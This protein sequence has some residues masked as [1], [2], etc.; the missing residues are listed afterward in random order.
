M[1]APAPKPA[2]QAAG[3]ASSV[4]RHVAKHSVRGRL[5]RTTLLI[6]AVV[7]VISMVAIVA[8]DLYVYRSSWASDIATE[9]GVVAMS[10]TP[11]LAFDDR[12]A[13]T[14]NLAMLEARGSVLAVAVYAR[15]GSLFA[16]HLRSDQEVPAVA[17][18]LAGGA[19]ESIVVRGEVVEI[20]QRIVSG[21]EV[22][23]T[24]YLR[25]R[26]DVLGRIGTYLGI[27]ALIMGVGLLLARMLSARLQRSITVPLETLADVAKQV[28]Q[29]GDYGLRMPDIADDDFGI[30]VRA[31]NQMFAEVQQRTQALERSNASLLEQVAVRKDA[32]SALARANARLESTMAAAEIGSWVWN[33]KTGEFSGDRNM[34]ALYGIG[35]SGDGRAD[36]AWH[37]RAIHPQD[38]AKIEQAERAALQSGTLASPEYRIVRPDGAVRWAVSRGRVSFDADGSPRVLAGLL[39]DVTAQ[40]LAEQERRESERVFRAI[41]ESINYGVWLADPEGRNTY[42]S[43]SFLRLT[44]LTQAQCSESGWDTVLHP[45][46]AR[47]TIDGWRECVRSGQPWYREHRVLGIDGQ[48]HPVLVQGLPIRNDDGGITV[49]AGINL[50]VSRI[51]RT[52]D[53]L[54]QADRRKDD[55]LATLAHELR[56]PLAPVLNAA[57]L[58]QQTG[59]TDAQR[60][61]AGQVI[62]R[63]VRNMALLL[64]DLLDVSR[65]TRG[66]LEVKLQRVDLD[67]LVASATETARPLID[68]KRHRLILDLPVEPVQLMVDPLRLSQAL[69]NLL[70]NAAKY[71]DAGGTLKI[72]A[73][74]DEQGLGLSMSDDG[75][76][77]TAAALPQVFEMFSQVETALERSQGGLGIGLALVRGLVTLHGGT[78][79]AHSDGPGRG[80]TFTIRLPPE[81]L[82]AD[83][84]AAATDAGPAGDTGTRYTILVVDDNRD[85]AE[86]LAILLV[87]DGHQVSTASSGFEA[88]AL[89]RK[90][91][92]QVLILDIGM[93]LMNGYELARLV[94][95]DAWSRDSLLLALT[96]WSQEQDVEQA[97]SAGFDRHFPK[98]VDLDVLRACL[99]E[100]GGRR[101][102][103]P[104]RSRSDS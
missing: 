93:P 24:L 15:D 56:N 89:A 47:A 53:A 72:S 33:V 75:I 13:A 40:K 97:R 82:V 88:L 12:E 103:R 42:T 91:H 50:D 46:D 22:L 2:T 14:H 67:S 26:Y 62:G 11:A 84:P 61:W 95:A 98:P 86:S 27:F 37:L 104:G 68:A 54:R 70:T 79:Q 60:Q 23:G 21:G 87:A 6:T 5:A 80:S 18:A 41:G 49:W 28:V 19:Q 76:G 29:R 94:R 83:P 34:L 73:W 3:F 10:A 101:S 16:R 17:P 102:T 38:R 52:E 31:F 77:L 25:A 48:Y 57:E 71:T 78:V 1:N 65:I 66:R 43:E 30:V 4:G 74:L 8:H 35:Q 51:K 92:P 96:G 64:D 55:F 59:T 20:T 100:F 36:P 69:S 7:L 44:G 85:A 81:V 32:E 9:A 45:E 63:Q 99:A 90:L 39:I 58:L